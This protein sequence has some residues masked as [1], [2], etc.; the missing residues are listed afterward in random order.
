MKCEHCGGTGI[1]PSG[2]TPG[3]MCEMC[4]G[5]GQELCP[6]CEAGWDGKHCKRC[7]YVN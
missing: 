1:D 4:Y 2:A 5:T 6:Y 3:A 7:G